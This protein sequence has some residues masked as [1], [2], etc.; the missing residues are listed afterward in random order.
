MTYRFSRPP[1]GGLLAM[2]VALNTACSSTEPPTAPPNLNAVAVSASE[3]ELS[4]EPPADNSRVSRY[5]LSRNGELIATTNQT[6]LTDRGLQAETEYLYEI[7]A[8]DGENLSAVASYTL[9]TLPNG[10]TDD[11]EAVIANSVEE[12]S[13]TDKLGTKDPFDADNE[14]SI[15]TGTRDRI[16]PPAPIDPAALTDLTDPTDPTAS[17]D[18]TD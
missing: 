8:S 9:S 11:A 15:D 2:L 13:E 3:I 5:E 6:A 16:D 7:V 14:D 1:L 10:A 4:W 17:T 18:L 12:S